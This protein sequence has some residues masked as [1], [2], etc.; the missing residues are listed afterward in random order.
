MTSIPF[1]LD[2]M[3]SADYASVSAIFE[4]GIAG[5][6]ATYDLAAATWEDWDAKHVSVCRWVAKSQ[7]DHRVLGWVALSTVSSRVVF[8]GVA[9]LSIYLANEAKGIGIGDA[10]MAKIVE[11]SESKGFWMLQ[12]GIFPENVASLR[13]HEKHGFRTVG[14][15]ERIGQMRSGEWRDIVLMERRSKNVG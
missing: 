4:Q 10:L 11:D 15:R 12:S 6:N 9:E 1:Y 3:V 5:G 13:L 14:I 7:Q 8:R 2:T